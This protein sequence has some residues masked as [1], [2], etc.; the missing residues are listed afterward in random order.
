MLRDRQRLLKR[1]HGAKKV[2]NPAA[3][4]AIAE[5]LS[6]EIIAAEQRVTNGVWPRRSSAIRKTCQ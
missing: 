6:A 4:Q 5:E 2:K 3:Q 1:L